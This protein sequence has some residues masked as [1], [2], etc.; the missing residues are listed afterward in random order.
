MDAEIKGKWMEA[1]RSGS[2][3]QG[4]KLLRPENDRWCCL[5]VLCNLINPQDWVQNEYGDYSWKTEQELLPWQT[6]DSVGISANDE[7]ILSD[8]NDDGKTFLE[9][10]D[11]IEA[12]L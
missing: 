10:A 8:M 6:N 5:G 4:M 11:Y 12:N 2:Y 1:L 9:I 7:G 3:K